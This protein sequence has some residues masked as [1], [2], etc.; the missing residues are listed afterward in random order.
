MK[1]ESSASAPKIRSGVG[2]YSTGSFCGQQV[3]Q[4]KEENDTGIKRRFC[5]ISFPET[6]DEQAGE[7]K[8]CRYDKQKNQN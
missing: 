7:E 3:N 6:G 5:L 1:I 8:K 4:A 2:K